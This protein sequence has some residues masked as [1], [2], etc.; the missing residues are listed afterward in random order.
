[1]G[2]GCRPND[3]AADLLND[4]G[5]V[6]VADEVQGGRTSAPASEVLATAL[7][8]SHGLS[9]VEIRHGRLKRM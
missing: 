2:N 8:L 6:M 3:V 4:F 5:T 1:M 7:S 9:V